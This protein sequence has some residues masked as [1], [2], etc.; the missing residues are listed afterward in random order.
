MSHNNH[1]IVIFF[2]YNELITLNKI[3]QLRNVSTHI[4]ENGL[5]ARIHYNPQTYHL[6][7]LHTC[8][9]ACE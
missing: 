2:I 5:Q 9:A 4:H 6:K 1:N 3:G 7:N 8:Q